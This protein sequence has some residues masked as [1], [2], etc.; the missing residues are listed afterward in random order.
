MRKRMM[1]LVIIIA[2][3]VMCCGNAF[4]QEN[5]IIPRANAGLTGGLNPAGNGRY[6][7]WGNIQGVIE[8]LTIRIELK[9]TSGGYIDS[10][11]SSGMG[12]SITTSK[13]VNLS[14]GT[15]YLYIYG[16]TPTDSPSRVVTVKAQ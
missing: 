9:T 7:M 14:K 12:P 13:T 5:E 6:T 3:M 4:A 15:Y 11:S 8:S 10:C 2:M 16:T 1:S